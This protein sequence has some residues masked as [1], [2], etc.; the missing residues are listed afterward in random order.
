[1]LNFITLFTQVVL[2]VELD[3]IKIVGSLT[4]EPIREV[5]VLPLTLLRLVCE[6]D[7][8]EEGVRGLDDHLEK[9]LSHQRT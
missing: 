3:L 4:D 7:G 1:M 5:R 2:W 8:S 6:H 9:E